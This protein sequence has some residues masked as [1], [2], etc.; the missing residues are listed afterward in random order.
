LLEFPY[1]DWPWVAKLS[2]TARTSS[3]DIR[4]AVETDLAD[5]LEFERL[6]SELSNPLMR[7]SRR[8]SPRPE[9]HGT[10]V[11]RTISRRA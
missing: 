11:N 7:V 4:A 6:L 3:V 9:D 1:T 5:R 8:E 10:G 2:S